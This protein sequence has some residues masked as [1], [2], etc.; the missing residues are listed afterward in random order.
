MFLLEMKTISRD[1]AFA[2]FLCGPVYES[3][4]ARA[5]MSRSIIPARFRTRVDGSYDD[6]LCKS[7]VPKLAC[8]LIGSTRGGNTTYWTLA[9]AKGNAEKLGLS[10]SK[11]YTRLCAT[12]HVL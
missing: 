12:T 7:G 5:N 9:S 4:E 10:K 1:G 11:Y 8:M 6:D 2:A 3:A